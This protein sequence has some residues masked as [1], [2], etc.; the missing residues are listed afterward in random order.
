MKLYISQ[1]NQTIFDISST[2]DTLN[3]PHTALDIDHD[4]AAREQLQTLTG[5]L[6]TPTLVL[7]DGTALIQPTPHELSAK[8][9]PLLQARKSGGS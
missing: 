5:A 7:P 4:P 1:T 6:D 2:L 8:L 3:L 9:L